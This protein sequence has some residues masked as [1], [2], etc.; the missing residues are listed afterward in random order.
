VSLGALGGNND[1]EDDPCSGS[2]VNEAFDRLVLKAAMNLN[3]VGGRSDA[4][5]SDFSGTGGSSSIID[6]EGATYATSETGLV[7][8]WPPPPLRISALF[9]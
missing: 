1:I 8:T 9:E 6:E 3:A 4:P 5:C 7:G 2:G